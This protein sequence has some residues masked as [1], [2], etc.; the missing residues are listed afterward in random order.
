[1][2][3]ELICL[4]K[5]KIRSDLRQPRSRRLFSLFYIGAAVIQDALETRL[6]LRLNIAIICLCFLVL[7][8]LSHVSNS[9]AKN[10]RTFNHDAG[11]EICLA[12]TFFIR[13]LNSQKAFRP[14]K[15]FYNKGP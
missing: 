1:M 2:S 10:V 3:L 13:T 7:S 4:L 8:K 11:I 14:S 5:F 12:L 9:C 6:D 15:S